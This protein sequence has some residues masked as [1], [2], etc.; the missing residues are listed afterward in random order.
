MFRGAAQR[1]VLSRRYDLAK[2]NPYRIWMIQL[3]LQKLV[4]FQIFKYTRR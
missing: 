3:V 1:D 2:L 4:S